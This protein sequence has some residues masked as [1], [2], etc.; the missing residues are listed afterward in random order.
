M[1]ESCFVFTEYR[2]RNLIAQRAT[3]LKRSFRVSSDLEDL[4]N[5]EMT[6]NLKWT[7]KTWK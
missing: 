3:P 1:S 4:E 7:W 2:R 5:L 6:W